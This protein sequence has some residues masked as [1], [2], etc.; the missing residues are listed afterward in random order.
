MTVEN[1]HGFA[2]GAA[3]PPYF[4]QQQMGNDFVPQMKVDLPWEPA[5]SL[6]DLQDKPHVSWF[7]FCLF[8]CLFIIVWCVF[9]G[10]DGII[11]QMEPV[12]NEL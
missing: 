1:V 10:M 3:L 8:D 12:T 9:I 2:N 5:R 6:S 11:K 4:L 7:V